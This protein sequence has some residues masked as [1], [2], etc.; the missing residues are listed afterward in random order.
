M[1]FVG[2]NLLWRIFLF[3]FNFAHFKEKSDQW[4]STETGP[5]CQRRCF[6]ANI[7]YKNVTSQHVVAALKGQYQ[8][9]FCF[10]FFHESVSPQPHTIPLGPFRIFSKIRGDIRKSRCTGGK[11]PP[12]S[13]VY[14]EAW[15]K[16]IHEKNQKSK[17][18]V[19]LSL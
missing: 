11:L 19:T 1:L 13:T 14:S 12:V 7:Y 17:N 18:L 6:H 5:A 10:W 2:L 15:G 4:E 3:S 9:I 8:E 16:V